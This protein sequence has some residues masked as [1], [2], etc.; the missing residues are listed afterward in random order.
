M[1]QKE[2]QR[3]MEAVPGQ[4]DSPA[5]WMNREREG[6][7]KGVIL[8]K[9][10]ERPHVLNEQGYIKRLST[11]TMENTASNNM[12]VFI[13]RI[14]HHS[15]KHKHQGGYSLFVLEG[16]GYTTV[17]GVR[18][19]WEEGD[20]VLL[21]I[22]QGGVEHQHFNED[23]RGASRWMALVSRPLVEILSRRVEQKDVH[24]DWKKLHGDKISDFEN[25]LKKGQEKGK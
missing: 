7:E 2:A 19:D 16:K 13:H 8:V 11:A 18:H 23:P 9:G 24:P 25:G 14:I 6:L 1:V 20:L 5:P 10:K 22:K 4:L 3:E 12:M 17:D 21:P 15:G